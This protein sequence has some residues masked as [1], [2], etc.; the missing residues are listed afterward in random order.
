M[1][2]E[3]TQETKEIVKSWVLTKLT[4]LMKE[5]WMEPMLTELTQL[6]KEVV[7]VQHWSSSHGQQRKIVSGLVFAK[8]GR[9]MKNFVILI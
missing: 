7:D 3:F 1:S 6:P 8:L 9:L 5:I 4:Q 2:T